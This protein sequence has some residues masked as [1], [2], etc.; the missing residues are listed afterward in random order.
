MRFTKAE[1]LLIPAIELSPLQSMRELSRQIGV[2]LHVAQHAFQSLKERGV[3]GPITAAIDR[4]SLGLIDYSFSLLLNH[5]AAGYTS[6]LSKVRSCPNVTFF[7][8]VGGEY[9]HTL[10]IAALSPQKANEI[11]SS[12]LSSKSGLQNR[13]VAIHLSL[14]NFPRS[15]LSAPRRRRD[16]L[17]YNRSSN[18]FVCDSVDIALLEKLAEGFESFREVGQTLGIS[19]ATVHRRV[20]RLEQGGVIAG[21]FRSVDPLKL[22]L[23]VHTLCVGLLSPSQAL[24]PRMLEYAQS[25]SHITTLIETLGAWDY[26]LVVEAES[27]KVVSRVVSDLHSNFRGELKSVQHRQLMEIY[28]EA[29]FDRKWLPTVASSA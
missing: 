7:S 23:T 5:D 2:R 10:N 29:Q 18:I 24:R 15:C 11:L 28:K 4:N 13:A 16:S 27:Q 6:L 12:L 26:E 25:N 20:A 3:L 19:A 17:L 8:Q 1:A 21:Y 9:T 14:R 22:D